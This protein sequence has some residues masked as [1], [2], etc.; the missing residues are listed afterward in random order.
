M[1][2]K[3]KNTDIHPNNELN[4]TEMG[5]NSFV[6]GKM[7]LRPYGYSKHCSNMNS[8]NHIKYKHK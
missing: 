7:V 5:Y 8:I 3:P 6:K 2:N 4:P 1:S